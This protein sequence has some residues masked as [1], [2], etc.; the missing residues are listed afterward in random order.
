MTL[1]EFVRFPGFATWYFAGSSC[2]D[3]QLPWR[4]LGPPG[5][6]A[7]LPWADAHGN[8]MA[9]LRALLEGPLRRRSGFT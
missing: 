9:A 4:P 5:T 2:A 8:E 1:R 7:R 3:Q 6:N